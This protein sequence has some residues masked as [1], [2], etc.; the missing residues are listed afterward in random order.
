M[1]WVEEVSV[2]WFAREEDKKGEFWIVW[3]EQ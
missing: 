2:V 1:E 3:F